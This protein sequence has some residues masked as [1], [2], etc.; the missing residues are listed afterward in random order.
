LP[1]IL[2]EPGHFQA[3]MRGA[4]GN[5]DLVRDFWVLDDGVLPTVELRKTSFAAG[6]G[7]DVRWRNG[8]GNRNDYIAAY[9]TDASTTYDNGLAWTYVDA[10]P[11]G[12]KRLDAAT[13]TWG[14]PLAPGDYVIRLVRDDGYDVLAESAPFKVM[15]RVVVPDDTETFDDGRLPIGELLRTYQKLI[16]KGWQLDVVFNSR[17]PGTRAPLPI[18]ALRSPHRGPATW[19]LAGI[20]GEEPAGP[21]AVAAAIDDIAA[22]GDR[23]PVVLMPL[24][25]PQGYA[26]NWRYLNVPIYS[27]TIDGM[28]VGDSSHL[29]P[30]K[31]NP[32]L[33]R[34]AVSSAEAGAISRYVLET[35]K[36]YPPRYSIDL[37]EDN[38]IDQGYVYSQGI[39]GAADPL[40][41]EAVNILRQNE[42]G[43]KISGQTRFGEDITDGIIGPV[44]DS[45]ID[46]LMS[47]HHIVVNNH[48]EPGPGAQT[49]LVFETPA[50]HLT[51]AQRVSAHAALI[52]RLSRLIGNAESR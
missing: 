20:H 51:L 45:S 52:Q 26:R 19:L 11:D 29:L 18:I 37:H 21:N 8:P 9:A 27:E 3:R 48:E 28:S 43:I 25:N 2:F 15:A 47:S 22:L 34:A 13:V 32:R 50:A 16:E 36:T 31:E 17:P 6:E 5:A 24:L 7:I 4:T 41:K 35:A 44:V 40:A 39:L 12:M 46:E 14:W 30:D 33:A 49:V 38:L 10:L 42:I 1:A 23:Q